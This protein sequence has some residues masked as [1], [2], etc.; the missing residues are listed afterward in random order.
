MKRKIKKLLNAPAR[1][2]NYKPRKNVYILTDK[3]LNIGDSVIDPNSNLRMKQVEAAAQLL[4]KQIG[5]LEALSGSGHHVIN[6]DWKQENEAQ[7]TEIDILFEEIDQ[8]V[9]LTE[10]EK[11]ARRVK[12]A[13]FGFRGV[14]SK[15]DENINLGALSKQIHDWQQ[16]KLRR[17]MK[18]IRLESSIREL[19]LNVNDVRCTQILRDRKTSVAALES[20]MDTG[21][22]LLKGIFKEIQKC[23]L[24]P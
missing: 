24:Q 5:R 19:S 7:I 17:R 16:E 9:L 2:G 11:C 14:S 6:N 23:L 8:G 13:A 21:I 10:A 3:S 12:K 18:L 15:G 4:L 20:T 22:R 1:E